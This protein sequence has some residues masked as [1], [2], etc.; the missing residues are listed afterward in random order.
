M[1]MGDPDVDDIFKDF[2]TKVEDKQEPAKEEAPEEKEISEEEI[3]KKKYQKAEQALK[4]KHKKEREALE[5]KR[6]KEMVHGEAPTKSFPNVERVAYIAIIIV[7]AAYIIV[8]WSF[9]HG[10]KP[11][12]VEADT[13]TAAAV[14]EENKINEIEEIVEEET[15]EEAEEIEEEEKQLSGVI[16]LII[17]QIYTEVLDED[18]DFGCISKVVFTI[19]NGKDKILKPFVEAYA[20]DSENI[21]DYE[22]K[23]RGFYTY[24]IGINPGDNHTGSIDLVPKTWRNLDLK[25]HIRLVLNDTEDGYITAWNEEVLIS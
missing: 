15:V 1:N 3:L 2:E 5:E 10:E 22:T 18:E 25:K 19:S 12:D 23:S 14:K 13:I 16:T 8:D 17:D 7:L 20:Y 9:Y 24:S 11:V 21:E 6:K 4:E